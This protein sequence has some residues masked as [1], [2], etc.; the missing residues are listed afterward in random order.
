MEDILGYLKFV[1]F[2]INDILICSF[3]LKEHRK[4]LEIVHFFK[5]MLVRSKPKLEFVKTGIE[6]LGLI[7]FH[8]KVE[9]QGHALKDLTKFL[10]AIYDHRQL[11]RFLGSLNYIR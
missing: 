3:D 4:H 11:Q 7:L 2:Y 8:G 10:D 5:H 9:L 6:Y 1:I